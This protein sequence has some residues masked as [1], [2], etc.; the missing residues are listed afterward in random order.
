MSKWPGFNKKRAPSPKRHAAPPPPRG[1]NSPISKPPPPSKFGGNS[2][3]GRTPTSTPVIAKESPKSILKKKKAPPPPPRRESPR[4]TERKDSVGT[5]QSVS[6]TDATDGP[7]QSVEGGDDASSRLSPAVSPSV[8]TKQRQSPNS[9]FVLPSQ[10]AMT[11]Q[12]PSSLLTAYSLPT[13]SP[14]KDLS[15]IKPGQV[16]KGN[17]HSQGPITTASESSY[18]RKK[19]MPI[20]LPEPDPEGNFLVGC[21]MESSEAAMM[22]GWQQKLVEDWTNEDIV[23]WLQA[24]D[25]QDL[26]KSLRAA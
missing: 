14:R 10:R 6:H 22:A 1:T 17:S 8:L 2:Q 23:E 25:Q 24:T 15:L 4:T 7:Y 16:T 26:W 11:G 13:L 5:D 18:N 19:F 3:S 20:S 9:M 21:V 12:K